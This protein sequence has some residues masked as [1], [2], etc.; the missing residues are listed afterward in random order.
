MSF[1]SFLSVKS[2]MLIRPLNKLFSYGT[3]K[4]GEWYIMEY[5]ESGGVSLFVFVVWRFNVILFLLQLG[6]I[7][8]F[9]GFVKMHCLHA[10][11]VTF[12]LLND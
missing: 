3:N 2:M 9:Y 4:E 11:G 6:Q 10:I 8:Y 7:V 5:N 1:L 12:F